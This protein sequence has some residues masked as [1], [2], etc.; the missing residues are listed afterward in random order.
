[1]CLTAHY[2]DS[3]WNLK[4]KILSF[5]AFPPPHTGAAIATKVLALLKEWGLDKRVFTITVDNASSNDNMQGILKRQLRRNLVC[6]GEFFH[7]RCAAHILNLIVQSGLNVIDGALEKVRDSVKYVKASETRELL[8]QGCIE[9]VGIEAKAGVVLDVLTRWNSTHLMLERALMYKEAFSHLAEVDSNFQTFPTESEWTRA[10]L[11]HEFLTPFAEMTNLI[12]G[13]TYPTANLY[14][15]QVWKIQRW[16]SDHEFSLDSVISEMVI[17]MKEKFD[18]Y[19]EDYSDILAVAAVF[20]PRLKFTFL[21][22]CFNTLY[23]STSQTKLDHVRKKLKKLFEVY[24]KNPK[25][26]AGSSQANTLEQNILP[27]YDGFYAFISQRVSANGKSALDKY[28]DE[29]V[30]DMMAFKSLDVLAY[31]RDNANRFN[32]LSSMACDVLSIPI[33]TVA[34]ESSFSIGSRVLNKYRSSLLPSNVQALICA[35][36]WLRGYEEIFDPFDFSG[37]DKEG[38]GEGEGEGEREKDV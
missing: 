27:G 9:T 31:W 15:M 4:S 37:E 24:R 21:E 1:M 17:N 14:F 28:L 11:I 25:K 23:A 18:K 13:S 8:F 35:R 26:T 29:P 6:N 10:V 36:N 12:S 16:L 32:G 3:S 33:T 22:Y 5:C 38:E 2:I 19:W 34:S 30:L 20:D 7:V